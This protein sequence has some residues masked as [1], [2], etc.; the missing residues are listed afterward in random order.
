M[1]K[2]PE[3]QRHL[4]CPEWQAGFAGTC[5]TGVQG[6][7]KRPVSIRRRCTNAVTNRTSPEPLVSPSDGRWFVIRSGSTEEGLSHSLKMRENEL[8]C[9]KSREKKI[10]L[11][12]A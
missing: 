10:G 4:L 7:R 12:R 2:A 1:V 9:C 8:E 11:R 5:R 6:E 3:V